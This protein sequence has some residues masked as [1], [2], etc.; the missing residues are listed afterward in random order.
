MN[1][2]LGILEL[3]TQ[4][5]EA[6]ATSLPIALYGLAP[7]AANCRGCVGYFQSEAGEMHLQVHP[8][9]LYPLLTQ[10]LDTYTALAA[11]KRCGWT[12][13]SKPSG[14]I[15]ICWMASS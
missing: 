12:A 5:P 4:R 3:E 10:A 2:I 13:I 8:T 11:Q 1:A 7:V 14:S 9:E 15:S 6:A